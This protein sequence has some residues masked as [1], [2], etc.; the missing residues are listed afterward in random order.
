MLL[1][2][3]TEGLSSEVITCRIQFETTEITLQI[4]A[5]EGFVQFPRELALAYA[6][7]PYGSVDQRI[8]MGPHRRF[9]LNQ[10]LTTFDLVL[11]AFGILIVGAGNTVAQDDPGGPAG[12][13][14]ISDHVNQ[15]TPGIPSQ[16]C[17]PGRRPQASELT[18]PVYPL[19]PGD[20]AEG[21][22]G[23]VFSG[24]GSARI[25]PYSQRLTGGRLGAAPNLIGDFFGTGDDIIGLRTRME[26]TPFPGDLTFASSTDL[27]NGLVNGTALT[28]AP[29]FDFGLV[30][31]D[32]VGDFL[33]SGQSFGVNGSDLS[34]SI[35]QLNL[36]SGDSSTDILAALAADSSVSAL[37]PLSIPEIVTR[38]RNGV[39]LLEPELVAQIN[40]F[41]E[42]V[43]LELNTSQSTIQLDSATNTATPTFVYDVFVTLPAPSPGDFVGRV[44]FSDNNSPLPRD[45]VYF[46]YNYFHNA[47][48]GP[49]DVPVNRFMPGVEKTFA[50]GSMSVELRL[51]MAVTLSSTLT[52]DGKDVLAYEI[53][54]LGI[55]LKALLHQTDTTYWTAGFGLTVPT[56]D[57]FRLNMADGTPL[58]AIENES[59]RLAPYAAVLWEPN[60]DW[61]FQA[62][63]SVE[64][65]LSGNQ[66]RLNSDGIADGFGGQLQTI[67]QL[68]GGTLY[69]FD[70]S[71]GMWVVRDRRNGKKVTDIAL[72]AEAHVTADIGSTDIVEVEQLS[73]GNTGSPTILNLVTGSHFYFGESTVL[74]VGFGVPVTRDRIFDGELRIFLNKYF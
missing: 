12:L 28:S 69:K 2:S 49:A 46:D 21:G 56:S 6:L 43:Q 71:A 53:G 30:V 7:S 44:V 70:G 33:S 64:A 37:D 22:L 42:F 11:I 74:T 61:F 17:A 41:S 59:V 14:R 1:F 50:D 38:I 10:A 40:S 4:H 24:D 67:G 66:V 63:T 36:Q 39:A 62:F 13:V 20:G 27:V 54:D 58:L 57:D 26:V 16:A 3:G 5:L 9:V 29:G 19:N 48:F 55:A 31:L 47:T 15:S 52:T 8:D 51:P 65:D 72:V 32:N 73:V 25:N 60:D 18:Q 68:Q 45:R 34:P 35:T 23:L